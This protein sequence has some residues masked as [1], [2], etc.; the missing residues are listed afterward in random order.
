LIVLKFNQCTSKVF[1]TSMDSKF[2]Q[3][4]SPPLVV[5]EL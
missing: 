4:F 1:L 3:N 5:A 2:A